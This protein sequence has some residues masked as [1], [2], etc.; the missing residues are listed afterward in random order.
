MVSFQIK[1]SFVFPSFFCPK[2]HVLISPRV[3]FCCRCCWVSSTVM[4]SGFSPF[5]G[6]LYVFEYGMIDGSKYGNWSNDKAFLR[7]DGCIMEGNIDILFLSPLG[8]PFACRAA[9]SVI[10]SQTDFVLFLSWGEGR[11]LSSSYFSSFSL[12]YIMKTQRINWFVHSFQTLCVFFWGQRE[13]KLDVRESPVVMIFCC[14]WLF[15]SYLYFF[16]FSPTQPVVW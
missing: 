6:V 13:G 4:T 3:S 9:D 12:S 14:P 1:S 16:N 5:S 11:E 2:W 10:P 7:R 15:L 8:I